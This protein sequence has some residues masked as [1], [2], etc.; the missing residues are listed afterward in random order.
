MTPKKTSSSL[1]K[2]FL[3]FVLLALFFWFL[4]K[5]SKNYESTVDVAVNFTDIPVNKVVKSEL[6]R[7]I[8]IHVSASGFKL[9]YANLIAPKISISCANL[10]ASYGDTFTLNLAA[11]K[12]AIQK[13]LSNGLSIAYFTK[14]KLLLE[15]DV[16]DTKKVAVKPVVNIVFKGNYDAYGD[17]VL[18]PDSML[19]SGPKSVLDTLRFLNTS[20]LTLVDVES[21]ISQDLSIHPDY[22]KNGVVF[23]SKT[24]T[25][26]A[27]VDKFT[28]GSIALPFVI[29]NEPNNNRIT[30]FPNV[31]KLTYKVGLRDYN[32]VSSNLFVIECDFKEAQE[33]NLGF[34]IPKV[35]SFPSFIKDLHL[36]TQKIDFFITK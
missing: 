8:E 19:V 12:A 24:I 15:F 10:E 26:S 11:Q 22:E 4:T 1:P 18:Q 33:N 30:T 14:P 16:L 23:D 5:L 21:N 36:N 31:V 13:Q 25:Y 9:F 7:T 32:K 6:P 2:S 28:E 20:P 29:K 34:M 27:R 35:V 17:V 3:I